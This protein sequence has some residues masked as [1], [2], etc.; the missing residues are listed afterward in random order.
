METWIRV[1]VI[2]IGATAATDL[3][4]LARRRLLG[5]PAPNFGLV[6]RWLAQLPRGRFR[7]GAIA[8]VSPVAGESMIGWTAHYLIGIA[9]ATLLPWLWGPSW[10]QA[11]R[12]GP[13][14]AV[15]IATVL[16]PFLLMQPGMGAGFFASRTPRPWTAR[17]H[18]LL[19]HAV[20][21]LGLF[22]SAW[23]LDRV[24]NP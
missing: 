9:F 3:W 7:H 2:G 15:G 8:K 1:I 5:V 6:G 12:L 13:A 14:L 23:L 11:P 16:A 4:S 19:T 22:A 21:G 10:F 18:S 17:L 24:A 20:F